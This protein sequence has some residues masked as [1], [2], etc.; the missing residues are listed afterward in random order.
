MEK[1]MEKKDLV[2]IE[3]LLKKSEK[4]DKPQDIDLF[5]YT[6]VINASENYFGYTFQQNSKINKVSTLYL[7]G[8][9]SGAGKSFITKQI[10]EDIDFNGIVVDV[11]LF[12]ELHPNYKEIYKKYG[13][14]NA[15]YTHE[16][17]SRVADEVLKKALEEKVDVIL[18]GTLKSYETPLERVKTFKEK[19]YTV[20]INTVVVKGEKSYLSNLMRYEE[21]LER[22]KIPRLAPK[23]VHD[24]CLVGYPETIS[25]L[26][27]TG[28]VDEIKLYNRNKECVYDMSKTPNINPKQIITM[29][30][31]R[32]WSREEYIDYLKE[33]DKLEDKMLKR[34]AE[35]IE[36]EIMKDTKAEILEKIVVTD[37]KDLKKINEK[38]QR[39]VENMSIEEIQSHLFSSVLNGKSQDFLEFIKE[40]VMKIEVLEDM[41]KENIGNSVIKILNESDVEYKIEDEKI[42]LG[43]NVLTVEN[44]EDIIETRIMDMKEIFDRK[45]SEDDFT[46]SEE[47]LKANNII[48]TRMNVIEKGFNEILTKSKNMNLENIED[49][50]KCKNMFLEDYNIKISDKTLTKINNNHKELQKNNKKEIVE[51]DKEKTENIKENEIEASL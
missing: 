36:V 29:E 1:K 45:Q 47:R 18:D 15:K 14:E 41:L 30:F 37:D 19:G 12:R 10:R 46:F 28:L 43:D 34:N 51:V 44:G 6:D 24:K 5:S 16:F 2:N 39:T 32:E 26:Y 11:D 4:K 40:F 13:K 35:E 27:E 31:E 8:G 21:L 49:F 9:Q 3:A 17:A 42:I 33:W 50:T 38:N 7:L 25:K 20:E 22:K 23:E 48:D